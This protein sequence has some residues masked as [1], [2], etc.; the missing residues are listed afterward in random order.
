MTRGGQASWLWLFAYFVVITVA[1]LYFSP[2]GLSLVSRMAPTKSRSLVMGIW[3]TTNFTG[4]VFAGWLGSLWSGMTPPDFFLLVA[5]VAA[6]GGVL[7][8]LARKQLQD[9]LPA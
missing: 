7:L 6:A 8:V 2:I 9:L 5:G 1:E 3:L 4:N